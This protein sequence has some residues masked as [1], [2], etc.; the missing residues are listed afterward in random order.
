MPSL[1]IGVSFKGMRTPLVSHLTY[2]G[3]DSAGEGQSSLGGTD[4]ENSA[5]VP[6]PTSTSDTNTG[7]CG[8]LTDVRRVHN[9]CRSTTVSHLAVI[10][11]QSQSGGLS[12]GA[13]WLL[14]FSWRDKTKSTYE[15][16]FKRWNNWCQEQD[17][18]LVRGPI[19]DVLN[20]LAEL[21]EQ[22]YQYRSLN[23]YRSAISSVH[24]KID[25]SEVGKHPL[26][27]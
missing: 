21:F 4:V 1:R 13:S 7:G 20:F 6:P 12:E 2:T 16:I 10:R 5:M 11:H 23:S 9:A 3:K 27:A 25:G 24:E 19:A 8:N 14:E 15:S 22:E 26:V 18:D 17:R